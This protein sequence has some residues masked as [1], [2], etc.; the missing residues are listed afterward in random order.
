VVL[1]PRSNNRLAVG[2]APISLFLKKGI[3]LALGTDSL[4]SNDSL[5][6]FDE[7]RFLRREFP[8]TLTPAEVLAM[9]TTGAARALHLDKTVGS[10]EPGRRG[11]FLVIKPAVPPTSADLIESIIEEGQ[12]A[13][14]FSAGQRL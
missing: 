14:V 4:A 7:M 2:K 3:P 1:C 10:L 9:A 8:G 5:S 12:V 13:H 11:D 6:L